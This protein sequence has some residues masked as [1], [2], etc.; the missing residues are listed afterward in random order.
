[1]VH[2]MLFGEDAGGIQYGTIGGLQD[3]L[4]EL[5][6]VRKR[7]KQQPRDCVRWLGWLPHGGGGGSRG[8]TAFPLRVGL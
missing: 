3:Q 1:M 7:S 4:R 2:N 5:R 6:E 8:S